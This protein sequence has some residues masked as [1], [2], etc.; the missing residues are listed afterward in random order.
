M[1]LVQGDRESSLASHLHLKVYTGCFKKPVSHLNFERVNKIV[2]Q[3]KSIGSK[4][5]F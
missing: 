3:L 2:R 5:D 4:L 1:N